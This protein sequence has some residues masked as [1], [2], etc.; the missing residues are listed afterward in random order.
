MFLALGAEC[1]YV[2]E[3]MNRPPVACEVV[4]H[5][6]HTKRDTDIYLIDVSGPRDA[7]LGDRFYVEVGPKEGLRDPENIV[8]VQTFLD[9]NAWTHEPIRFGVDVI[10]N[11]FVC[12]ETALSKYFHKYT[13]K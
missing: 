7:L 1:I 11:G 2:A 3:Y 5:V 9:L 6:A 12:T 8:P 13:D 4:G 10:E